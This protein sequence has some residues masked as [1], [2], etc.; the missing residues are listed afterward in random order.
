MNQKGNDPGN[1]SMPADAAKVDAIKK[2]GAHLL[3]IYNGIHRGAEVRLHPGEYTIGCNDECD[4]VL[5]DDG[6]E[7]E[8]MLLTYQSDGHFSVTAKTGKLLING[9]PVE[10]DTTALA[11]HQIVTIGQTHWAVVQQGDG[12]Q[13]NALPDS[14]AD[15]A[16]APETDEEGVLSDG[17]DEKN[18]K[19]EEGEKKEKKEK[20]YVRLKR[21]WPLGAIGVI[22][23]LFYYGTYALSKNP[24]E[25]NEL[26]IER[27]KKIFKELN[28]PEPNI[29]INA[30]GNMVVVGYV[31]LALDKQRVMEKLKAMPPWVQARIFVGENIIASCQIVLARLSYAIEADYV[32]RGTV[33]LKGFVS[34]KRDI[35]IIINKLKQ[36]VAGLQS[37]QE[38][39]WILNDVVPELNGIIKENKLDESIRIEVMNG[40]PVAVG[41][42]RAQE[43]ESWKDAKMTIARIFGD[44][45]ILKNNIEAAEKQLPGKVL[46]PIT[47][48]TLGE[49]PYVTLTGN[50]VYF[51]GSPLKNGLIISQIR[52]D[53]IVIDKNGRKYYY[54]LK[55]K[56]NDF[57][58]F[59]TGPK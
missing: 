3:Q 28:L 56:E 37:I 49:H 58:A 9:S 21:F 6:I 11:I 44:D 4:I 12:W 20:K 5:E 36:D 34:A 16:P 25:S 55:S 41:L 15:I 53:R 50:R 38:R 59:H 35:E 29:S 10:K 42:L 1:D 31:K 48:V 57:E 54:D 22:G 2:D 32:E 51:E 19:E 43:K 18:E 26:H 45:F 47:G 30:D 40:Y 46:L 23:L 52:S 7:P 39:V 14:E 27:V 17:E 8:H 33:L 13:P 24:V